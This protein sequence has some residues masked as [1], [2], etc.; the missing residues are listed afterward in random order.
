[1]K[2][3]QKF[4]I[5]MRIV[6]KL[7]SAPVGYIIQPLAT[8]IQSAER[9]EPRAMR[10]VTAMWRPRESRPQPKKKRPMNVDSRKNAIKPSIASGAPKMSPT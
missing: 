6:S 10:T 1:M 9:F 8:R 3:A 2:T 5:S 4:V 7:N